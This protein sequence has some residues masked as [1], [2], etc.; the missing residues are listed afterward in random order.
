MFYIF[1]VWTRLEL[2]TS[3]VTGR[4]S[5]QLNYHTSF[6][7]ASLSPWWERH[8]HRC[9]CECKVRRFFNTVQIFWGKFFKKNAFFCLLTNFFA[10]LSTKQPFPSGISARFLPQKNFTFYMQG[11]S[12]LLLPI[13]FLLQ[14]A[15]FSPALPRKNTRTHTR[16]QVSGRCSNLP[17]C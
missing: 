9:F 6:F 2:A 1:A 12:F 13:I 8:Q 5:N 11:E 10:V 14:H 7:F 3:C 4:H 16:T 15:I 17:D